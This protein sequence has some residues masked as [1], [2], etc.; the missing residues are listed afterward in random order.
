MMSAEIVQRKD[1]KLLARLMEY[2]Q[3]EHMPDII[4]KN[5]TLNQ[6]K[7]KV[8]GIEGHLVLLKFDAM[9]PHIGTRIL[10]ED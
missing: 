3:P 8:E 6:M 4:G 5:I 2:L 9:S 10:I 7:G 1:D